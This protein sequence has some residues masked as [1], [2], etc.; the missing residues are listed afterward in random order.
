[1]GKVIDEKLYSALILTALF[2]AV[3]VMSMI[4]FFSNSKK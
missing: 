4:K 2:E 1:S 3:I